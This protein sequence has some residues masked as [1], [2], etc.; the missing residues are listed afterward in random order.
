MAALHSDYELGVVSS[1]CGCHY[2]FSV[3]LWQIFYS[4]GLLTFG[5][6]GV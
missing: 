6:L 2:W 3:V 4:Q 1:L 5:S